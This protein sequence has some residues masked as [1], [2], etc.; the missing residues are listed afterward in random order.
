MAGGPR[1]A[2]PPPAIARP[3]TPPPP[4]R[5]PTAS[6]II[7]PKITKNR[8]P[9]YPK[10]ARKR[11][12]SAVVELSLSIDDKGEVRMAEVLNVE[13]ER[14][15]KDFITA[16]ERAAMRTRYSP[17]TV[18]GKAVPTSGIIKRYVFQMN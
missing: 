13:A 11:G 16:S 18:N 5:A 12:I 9:R 4:P 6:T 8:R 3:Y 1:A 14:Y 15:K 2:V 7:E 10:R 17:K